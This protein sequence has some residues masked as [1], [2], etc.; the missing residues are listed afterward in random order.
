M[1]CRLPLV[2]NWSGRRQAIRRGSFTS[3]RE[4]VATMGADIDNWNDHPAPFAWTKGADEIL[5]SIKR[6]KT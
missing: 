3:V 4:L 6:P 5:A 2:R 1:S